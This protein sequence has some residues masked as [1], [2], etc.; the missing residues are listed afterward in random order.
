M[1]FKIKTKMSNDYGNRNEYKLVTKM[2]PKLV[3]TTN[4]VE[5]PAKILITVHTNHYCLLAK[6]VFEFSKYQQI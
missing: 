5:N 6:C 3:L 4:Q 2:R 1:L